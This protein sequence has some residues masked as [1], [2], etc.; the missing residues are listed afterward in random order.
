MATGWKKM[1]YMGEG[2]LTAAG[3]GLP[4]QLTV[5]GTWAVLPLL[6]RALR[7]FGS[8]PKFPSFLPAQFD[9]ERT[10]K[11]GTCAVWSKMDPTTL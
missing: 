9:V 2:Q 1:L 5:K 3:F 10:R 6:L 11:R 7:E 8:Q 4:R